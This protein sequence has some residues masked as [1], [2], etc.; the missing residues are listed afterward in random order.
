MRAVKLVSIVVFSLLAFLAVPSPVAADIGDHA[1]GSGT[2]PT[3]WGGHCDQG[4]FFE[5]TATGAT[6]NDAVGTFT[7][8]CPPSDNPLAGW[9][10][11]GTISCLRI[12][13]ES[14][15]LP[16]GDA[17]GELSEVA[18][19]GGTVTTSVNFIAPGDQ[20]H[21]IV[22]DGVATDVNDRMGVLLTSADCGA[23]FDGG[24][25]DYVIESGAITVI[26]GGDVVPAPE[27]SDATDNDGDF[28]VDYP[29]DPG[30]DSVTD[31]TE[32][33]N[34]T[35]PAVLSKDDCK[36]GGYATYGFKNQGTCIASLN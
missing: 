36:K 21:F 34:P 24:G 12:W 4:A 29:A 1:S 8:T 18:A 31:T 23:A 13:D 10:M 26:D 17:Y 19:V 7:F 16:Y 9:T 2:L 20:L 15:L 30:C 35:P 32:S 33:P 3:N 6:G 25:P 22:G 11:T 14:E 27:C 5:F 28:L